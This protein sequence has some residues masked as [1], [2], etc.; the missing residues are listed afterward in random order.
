MIGI[1]QLVLQER[2]MKKSEGVQAAIE[3]RAALDIG[4]VIGKCLGIN[5]VYRK[6]LVMLLTAHSS[7]W[8]EV[9]VNVKEK[10]DLSGSDSLCKTVGMIKLGPA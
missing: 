8:Q 2:E 9:F 6:C 4:S 10:R 3:G 7:G 1:L 5:L